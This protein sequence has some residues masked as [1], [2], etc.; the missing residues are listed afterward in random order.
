MNFPPSY[1]SFDVLTINEVN[2]LTFL[3]FMEMFTIEER[4]SIFAA[5]FDV[6]RARMLK[7]WRSFKSK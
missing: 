6:A 3:G 7:L 2:N 4:R 5:S 1:H